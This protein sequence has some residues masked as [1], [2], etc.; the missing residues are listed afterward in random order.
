MNRPFGGNRVY[1]S[2]M[3]KDNSLSSPAYIHWDETQWVKD[4]MYQNILGLKPPKDVPDLLGR[5]NTLDNDWIR[6]VRAEVAKAR[7]E[8]AKKAGKPK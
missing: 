2:A 3:F 1:D 5:L 7:L 4:L 8:S 6:G